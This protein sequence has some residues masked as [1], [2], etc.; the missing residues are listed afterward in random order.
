M[1]IE[2]ELEEIIKENRE[3]EF[4]EVD[5]KIRSWKQGNEYTLVSANTKEYHELGWGNNH[6]HYGTSL[7]LVHKSKALSCFV[8]SKDHQNNLWPE[9]EE[10]FTN[11]ELDEQEDKIIVK[12]QGPENGKQEKM[13]RWIQKQ[14]QGDKEPTCRIQY[15]RP[16]ELWR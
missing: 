12:Y 5:W 2:Q 16:G 3:E 10:V 13:Y 1:E 14:A 15:R 4:G 11:L 6:Y 9:E 7:Y 8:D